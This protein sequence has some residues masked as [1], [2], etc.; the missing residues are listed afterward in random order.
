MNDL[1]DEEI[2][3]MLEMHEELE[4]SLKSRLDQVVNEHYDAMGEVEISFLKARDIS[5]LRLSET[6]HI[7]D[8]VFDAYIRLNESDASQRLDMLEQEINSIRERLA[9]LARVC[10]AYN[11]L[12]DVV[13]KAYIM[14]FELVYTPMEQRRYAWKTFVS[15]FGCSKRAISEGINLVLGLIHLLYNSEYSTPQIGNLSFAELNAVFECD[16]ELS[17]KMRNY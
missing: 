10:A 5:Q 12:V 9:E 6:Y 11:R 8:P 13:P 14:V 7:H 2:R 17:R 15:E 1:N 16:E 4:R 3:M